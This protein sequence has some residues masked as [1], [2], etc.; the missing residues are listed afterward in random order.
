MNIDA[1]I[2]PAG[3]DPDNVLSIPSPPHL[4]YEASAQPPILEDVFVNYPSAS[5]MFEKPVA[6]SQVAEAQVSRSVLKGRSEP[7][8]SKEAFEA[9]VSAQMLSS[10]PQT[11]TAEAVRPKENLSSRQDN[12]SLGVQLMRISPAWLLIGGLVFVSFIVLCNWLIKPSAEAEEA[13]AL[14]PAPTQAASKKTAPAKTALALNAPGSKASNQAEGQASTAAPTQASESKENPKASAA[15]VAETKAAPAPAP[16]S[17][18]A[19]SDS[20]T[21]QKG[22]GLTL[23]VGSYSDIGQADARVA[24]LKAAGFAGRVVSVEIPKRGTWY[25]VQVGRFADKAE[26]T[27]FGEQMRGKGAAESVIVTEAQK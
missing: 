4:A 14:R 2:I 24:S 9:A 19:S 15:P 23:Q 16:P 20:T 6:A 8:R 3:V 25:R 21:N 22:G 12:Y 26:A 1:K 7:V 10:S 5:S 17:P 27:R 11:K 13:Q 18:V